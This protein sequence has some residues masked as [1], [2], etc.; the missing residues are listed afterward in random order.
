MLLTKVSTGHS[1]TNG[2]DWWHIRNM[3]W[4]CFHCHQWIYCIKV[5]RPS[6]CFRFLIWWAAPAPSSNPLSAFLGGDVT[7][8]SRDCLVLSPCHSCPETNLRLSRQ[9]A[10]QPVL[11]LCASIRQWHEPAWLS[12]KTPFHNCIEVYKAKGGELICWCL[13]QSSNIF[14]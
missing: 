3:T 6:G 1:E 4:L 12:P 2:L 11:C 8:P 10:P 14:F 9:G 13:Q 5:P 7:D